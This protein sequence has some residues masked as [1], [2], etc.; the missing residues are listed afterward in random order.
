MRVAKAK[1]ADGL[2]NIECHHA[3][4]VT[5][6]KVNPNNYENKIISCFNFVLLW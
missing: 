3:G 6:Y 4:L 5:S 1:R 2:A